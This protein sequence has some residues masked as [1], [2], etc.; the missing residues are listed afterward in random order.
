MAISLLTLLAT[1][2]TLHTSGNVGSPC[3]HC[4]FNRLNAVRLN[5]GGNVKNANVNLR[6]GDRVG[7][8]GPTSCT[9]ISALA[10]LLSM[11][12]D[13]RGAGF[14]RK[15]IGVGT[16]GAAF[17]CL[18]VRFH[19][20]RGL[21][22]AVHVAPFS[23]VNCGFDGARAVHSSRSNVMAAAGHCCNSN[24]LHRIAVNLK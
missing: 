20:V 6:G 15:K 21:N 11:N 16:H 14:T 12:V 17:S 2:V 24:K 19:L 23:G 8:L 13:L 1:A 10:F 22:V 3:A 7:L 9:T 5:I 4:K 18:T